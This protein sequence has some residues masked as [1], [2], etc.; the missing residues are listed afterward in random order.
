MSAGPWPPAAIP[1]R[2]P[3]WLSATVDVALCVVLG[4]SLTAIPLA[5]AGALR[6]L[7]ASLAWV[8]L[9]A[10]LMALLLSRRR[11]PAARGGRVGLWAL[12]ALALAVGW[13]MLN[14]HY[15][16]QRVVADRDPGIYLWFGRWLADHGSLTLDNPG[17]LFAT[18]PGSFV[19]QCPVTCTGAPGGGLYVQFLHLES[20]VLAA[21]AWL[22]G[23]S[24]MVRVNAILGGLSLLTFFAFATRLLRPAFALLATIALAVNLVEVYFARDAWSE[25]LTQL[26][27]F[28]GLFE[29]HRARSDWSVRRAAVAGLL[30]GA[31][32]MAR[33]D[34]F[35]FLIP[36]TV[37]ALTE[38]GL[39]AASEP[40]ELRGVRRRFAAALVGGLAISATL[41]AV[42]LFFFSRGYYRLQSWQL[43]RIALAL[44]LLAFAG[45]GL[46][47]A[48][49]R[50]LLW[51]EGLRR[52]AARAA[53]AVPVLVLVLALGAWFVRPLLGH[54]HGPPSIVIRGLQRRA[55]LAIDPGRTYAED[56]MRWLSWYLGPIALAGGVV[57]FAV[58]LRDSLRGRLA[59]ATPFLGIFGTVT[60]LYILAPSIFP[61]QIVAARRYLPVTIPGLLLCAAWVVQWATGRVGRRSTGLPLRAAAARVAVPRV[62]VP[63]VAVVVLLVAGIVAIPA[64]QTVR[65]IDVREQAGG[66]SAIGRVCASLPSHAV[67]WTIAGLVETGMVEPVHAFCGV[68]VGQAP[69]HL[70]RGV[71]DAFAVR[72]AAQG[73]S[74][75]LLSSS[76]L[77]LRAVL[78]AR[79]PS[80]PVAVLSYRHLEQTLT[81][82]PSAEVRARVAFWLAR[83]GPPG[84]APN[85]RR[86]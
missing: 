43:H 12:G 38:Y 82:R 62:A 32:C 37:Y 25:I 50:G 66:L 51:A 56:A 84:V 24:A 81:R 76:R 61:D 20:A 71:L 5:M 57:G 8:V 33:V 74:L 75:V 79:A 14:A 35:L 45:A 58:L 83:A 34:A 77:A 52:L 4:F 17:H 48:G 86:P 21:G 28:G 29:L 27:L 73:R 41:A 47:A 26:L 42:D 7:P 46:L 9:S 65:L 55:G 80:R 64:Q 78:G 68:P 63:R 1:E 23:N 36:M 11:S 85:I 59:A 6:P 15:S 54:G 22:G 49:R 69:R 60:A 16:S 39:A 40:T 3:G 70:D 18:V 44:G 72:L 31:C 30:I 13:A 67:V 10:V 53:T 19:A 2:L